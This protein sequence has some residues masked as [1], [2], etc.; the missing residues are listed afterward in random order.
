VLSIVLASS[1]HALKKRRLSLANRRLDIPE[2][3]LATFRGV[4]LPSLVSFLRMQES[5]SPTKRNK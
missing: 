2:A 5:A 3:P 4:I 1:I